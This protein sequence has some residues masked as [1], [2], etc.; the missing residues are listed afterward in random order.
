M[1]VRFVVRGALLALGVALAATIAVLLFTEPGRRLLPPNVPA[2]P[3]IAGPGGELPAAPVG[4]VEQALYQGGDYYPVG[5]GF[6][7]ALPNGSRAGIT[8]AHSVSFGSLQHIA[9]AQHEFAD[10]VIDFDTLRGEP[11]VPR[12]GEDMSVDFVLLAVPPDHPLDP[13]LILEPDP[14]GLPQAGERLSMYTVLNDQPR[15]LEGS[16]LSANPTAIWVV[17]D[18]VFEPG[19]LSGSPFLSQHT[20]K[21]VGMTIATTRQGGKVLL[22]L[23]PIGSLVE[24]ALAAQVFPKIADYQR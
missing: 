22:G 16:V 17:M 18:E 21:V 19:G 5:R 10:R 13:G 14:R 23:H 20:G 15:I 3:I 4:L 12:S 7:L 8:T 6:I 2:A 1:N 9:L 11:G 24:K